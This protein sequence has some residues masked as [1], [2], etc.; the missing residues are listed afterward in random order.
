ME[1][2]HIIASPRTCLFGEVVNNYIPFPLA[3]L[4][5]KPDGSWDWVVFELNWFGNEPNRFEAMRAAN[6]FLLKDKK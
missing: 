6:E 5:R 3:E 2:H 4:K 1:W